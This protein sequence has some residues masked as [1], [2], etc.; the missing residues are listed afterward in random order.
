MLITGRR[1]ASVFQQ[2]IDTIRTLR[3]PLRVAI[4]RYRVAYYPRPILR[5]GG[6]MANIPGRPQKAIINCEF[7]TSNWI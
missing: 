3:K 2:L 5:F 6:V 4:S 7:S 1:K